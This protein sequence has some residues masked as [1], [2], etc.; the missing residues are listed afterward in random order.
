MH[1]CNPTM[2]GNILS[3]PFR[4]ITLQALEM[5][6]SENVEEI[7]VESPEVS[8]L[9]DEDLCDEDS[10][11]TLDNL[12]GRQLLSHAELVLNNNNRISCQEDI[13]RP[14]KNNSEIDQTPEQHIEKTKIKIQARRKLHLKD[15]K[16]QKT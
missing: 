12:T 11:G 1:I 15:L 4:R 5:V 3:K 6:Y 7:Y 8:S 16:K 10:G 9:T 2:L 14:D 13:I